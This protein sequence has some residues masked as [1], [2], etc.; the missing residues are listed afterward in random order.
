[1]RPIDPDIEGYIRKALSEVQVLMQKAFDEAGGTPV[2]GSALDQAGLRDGEKVV[3]D[4]LRH[5]E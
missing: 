5:G 4:F 3:L 1:M 2:P